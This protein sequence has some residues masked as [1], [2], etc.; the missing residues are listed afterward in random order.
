MYHKR[1]SHNTDAFV[2]KEEM[3][4]KH[5]SIEKNAINK[6]SILVNNNHERAIKH[7]Q[8]AIHRE[9]TNMHK[10][11]FFTQLFDSDDPRYFYERYAK[12]IETYSHLE[13]KALSKLEF[14]REEL[15]K[16][17]NQLLEEQEALFPAK[18]GKKAKPGMILLT[19]KKNIEDV[20]AS[21]AYQ[22]Y[23]LKIRHYQKAQD[24]TQSRIDVLK[25]KLKHEEMAKKA[26]ELDNEAKDQHTSQRP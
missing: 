6:N 12:R 1:R 3:K 20:I 19:A 14:Y 26:N 5:G 8:Q 2:M 10:I 11:R 9:K 24:I 15:G 16:L 18:P 23:A 25:A 22:S 4:D 21:P 7:Y 17:I 13:N